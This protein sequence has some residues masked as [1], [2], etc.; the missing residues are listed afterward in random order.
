MK[1]KPSHIKI[2]GYSWVVF[3]SLVLFNWISICL[4]FFNQ[5]DFLGDSLETGAFGFVLLIL[6]SSY[7]S[8]AD[9][10]FNDKHMRTA[11]TKQ[12]KN[13]PITMAFGLTA[14]MVTLSNTWIKSMLDIAHQYLVPT[15]K[16]YAASS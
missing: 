5:S 10:F 13:A 14:I 12:E 6:A 7:F 15:L 8:L 3:I 4:I 11:K 1:I 9:N 2:I 16:F